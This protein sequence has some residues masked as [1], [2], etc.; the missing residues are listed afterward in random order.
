M[1]NPILRA[2][3]ALQV[4]DVKRLIGAPPIPSYQDGRPQWSEWSTDNAIKEGFKRSTW[5]YACVWRIMR[6]AASVPWVVSRREG[7][8]WVPVPGHPLELLLETPN[9]KMSRQ[10]L[11]E[12]TASHL[13]LGGNA[14]WQKVTARNIVAELWPLDVGGIKPIISQRDFI[15]GYQYERGKIRHLYKADEVV[16][17]T[18]IDPANPYWGMSPLQAAA[19]TVDTDVEAVK[20]NK[21]A[22]QNRATPDGVFTH[23]APLTPEQ[24]EEARDHVRSQHQGADN[25]RTPWVLGGGAKWQQMSLS[26]AEMDFIESRRMTRL[27]ICAIFGVPPVLVGIFDDATLANAETSIKIFWTETVIPF[28]SDIRGAL[29]R[30]LVPLFGDPASLWLTYDTSNVEALQKSMED[31][32]RVGVELWKT[33]MPW[34]Q[35]AA[36]LDLDLQPWDGWDVSWIP[37]AM[38]SSDMARGLDFEAL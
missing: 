26:P 31:L 12:R 11:I 29:T 23:D 6:A 4:P 9:P 18:F 34:Q 13:Y 27:E 2:A 28:L 1:A 8:K 3:K 5:V 36:L 19:R 35:I 10:D 7:D 14:L 37:I 21:I 33:G 25:A 30:S 16:H 22:L 17:F 20:W 15:S 38:Q 32:V 24:W